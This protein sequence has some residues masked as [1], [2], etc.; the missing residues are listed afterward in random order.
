MNALSQVKHKECEIGLGQHALTSYRYESIEY[1][2]TM[3]ASKYEVVSQKR[4]PII[5]FDALA[6][7]LDSYTWYFTLSS[8]M[9]VLFVLILIQK[10][11]T[12]ASGHNPTNGW[13]FQGEI[14]YQILLMYS[15]LTV[16]SF[17]TLPWL[18]LLVLMNLYPGL[19]IGG[20]LSLDQ[21][22]CF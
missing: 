1:L 6:Y 11:W 9:A 19:C 21:E 17:K 22:G 12:N 14:S 2:P 15:Y 20:N 4:K 10:C 8:T 5:S 16:S 13:I 3:L 7:P 18:S